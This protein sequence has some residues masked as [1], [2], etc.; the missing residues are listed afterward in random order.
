M[1]ERRFKKYEVEEHNT[2]GIRSIDKSRSASRSIKRSGTSVSK[3]KTRSRRRSSKPK[4]SLKRK[5]STSPRP[6]GISNQDDCINYDS[7]DILFINEKIKDI[8][9]T[10]SKQSRL[11]QPGI[12]ILLEEYEIP[13]LFSSE[14]FRCIETGAGSLTSKEESSVNERIIELLSHKIRVERDNRIQAETQMRKL[15]KQNERQI[16]VLQKML[17]KNSDA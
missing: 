17:S 14:D 16:E 3:S 9:S 12:K 13:N 2:S 11:M 1:G 10:K 7:K 5:Q 4:R 8:L 6:E 15:E